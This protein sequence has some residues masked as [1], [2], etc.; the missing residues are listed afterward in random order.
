MIVEVSAFAPLRDALAEAGGGG[1]DLRLGG[2]SCRGLAALGAGAFFLFAARLLSVELFPGIE[3]GLGVGGLIAEIEGIARKLAIITII[4][5]IIGSQADN[6]VE[7]VADDRGVAAGKAVVGGLR[8]GPRPPSGNELL[9]GQLA[10]FRGFL[11]LLFGG[12]RDGERVF[13]RAVA[14]FDPFEDAQNVEQQQACFRFVIELAQRIV[15][16]P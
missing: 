2:L 3:R 8:P 15:G 7:E 4:M 13:G 16:L 10:V 5:I 14:L 6:A 11:F 9:V 1:D 12:L